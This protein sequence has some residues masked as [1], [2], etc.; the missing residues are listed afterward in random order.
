[1]AERS[2]VEN[3]QSALPEEESIMP[4]KIMPTVAV[5]SKCGRGFLRQH[6]KPV[7]YTK[8]SQPVWW[9]VDAE[10]PRC[11]GTIIHIDRMKQIERVYED[12]IL[13]PAEV[14]VI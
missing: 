6:N 13:D 1:M 4:I 3:P 5:C 14:L 2:T 10:G 7:T 8:D 12:A 9:L 11:D